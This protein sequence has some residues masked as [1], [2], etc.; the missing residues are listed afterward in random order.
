[1]QPGGR[2]APFRPGRLGCDSKDD[3]A[4]IEELG[5]PATITLR[6]SK[7]YK[8]HRWYRAPAG[9]ETLPYVAFRFEHGN[10]Y[11]DEQRYLLPPPAIHPSGVEYAFLQGLGP[12]EIE[13]AEL[14]AD[15]YM[16]CVRR[17]QESEREQRKR[18][19]VDPDATVPRHDRI[20]RYACALQNWMTSEDEILEAALAYNERHF[21]D[22]PDGP[23][24][25]Q[26]VRSHVRGPLR[27]AER[28]LDPDEAELR[29]EAEAFEREFLNGNVKPTP[30]NEKP[31]KRATSGPLGWDWLTGSRP[32]RGAPSRWIIRSEI[33]IE[34]LADGGSHR[35]RDQTRRPRDSSRTAA[36]AQA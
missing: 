30:V 7:P 4:A 11:A 2:A 23:M 15:A 8:Q 24:S 21:A 3:L 1:M 34:R 28:T 25:E 12:G 32:S 26:R 17:S 6:S 14:P 9:M 13:I 27:V 22:H 31:S 16:E 5:L 10:V 20:F 29:R 35:R 19:R 33:R 36:H 18:L